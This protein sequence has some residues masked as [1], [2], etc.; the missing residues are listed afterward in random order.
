MALD[1]TQIDRF[2]KT[3]IENQERLR[4][5]VEILCDGKLV[6]NQMFVNT[7]TS[8]LLNSDGTFCQFLVKNANKTFMNMIRSRYN[9]ILQ[10]YL[11]KQ[12]KISTINF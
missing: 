11:L 6:D 7:L 9:E 12:Q 8:N 3:S 2:I 1:S 4:I 10:R 5:C